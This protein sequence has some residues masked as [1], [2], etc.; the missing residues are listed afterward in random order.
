M[1]SGKQW[2]GGKEGKL[3]CMVGACFYKKRVNGRKEL[4]V[5]DGKVI[6]SKTQVKYAQINYG[7]MKNIALC[8]LWFYKKIALCY[9]LNGQGM[10]LL[11][12]L[13]DHI[14]SFIKCLGVVKLFYTTY[15]L[16]TLLLPM[17]F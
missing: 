4:T 14:K 9:S 17:A 16:D 8:Y 3:V 6:E 1:G 15:D 5:S 13:R 7:F 10:K 11:L 2:E 12:M